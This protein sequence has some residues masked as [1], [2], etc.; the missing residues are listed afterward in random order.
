MTSLVDLDRNIE[1]RT[2]SLETEALVET[3]IVENKTKRIERED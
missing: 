3:G 2:K 1:Y